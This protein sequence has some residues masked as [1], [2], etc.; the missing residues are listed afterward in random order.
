VV[1]ALLLALGRVH[2]LSDSIWLFRSCCKSFF[3]L[4]R[5]ACLLSGVASLH[6]RIF[7]EVFAAVG[8]PWQL[9]THTRVLG[10]RVRRGSV[11]EPRRSRV[12]RTAV[13]VR[14]LDVFGSLSPLQRPLGSGTVRAKT[15]EV[16]IRWQAQRFGCGRCCRPPRAPWDNSINWDRV[17]SMIEQSNLVMALQG[18]NQNTYSLGSTC[19]ECI[20]GSHY[21]PSYIVDPTTTSFRVAVGGWTSLPGHLRQ[22]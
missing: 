15:F 17:F 11:G 18:H 19:S 7:A 12:A 16:S 2:A 8:D 9:G 21:L 1:P 3:S 4:Q 14:H 10:S 22:G 6:L 5:V 13:L 20:L